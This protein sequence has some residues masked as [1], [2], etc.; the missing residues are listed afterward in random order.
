MPAPIPAPIAGVS[1]GYR[2][3][4]AAGDVLRPGEVFFIFDGTGGAVTLPPA[5][6][7]GGALVLCLAPTDGSTLKITAGG[8]DTIDGDATYNLTLPQRSQMLVS[9]GRAGLWKRLL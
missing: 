9:L 3:D 5:E 4:G 7:T 8:S 6:S 2:F 1:L